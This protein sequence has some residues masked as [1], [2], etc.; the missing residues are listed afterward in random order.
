MPSRLCCQAR[1]WPRC[2]S[3]QS[4]GPGTRSAAIAALQQDTG[5]SFAGSGP[6]NDP[7]QHASPPRRHRDCR[8]AR[9]LL[10]PRARAGHRRRSRSG[11][12]ACRRA[13][14]AGWHAAECCSPG[15]AGATGG[16]GSDSNAGSTRSTGRGGRGAEAGPGTRKS[17]GARRAHGGCGC[18]A[19]I[20]KMERNPG[21]PGTG[22]GTSTAIAGGSRCDPARRSGAAR[23]DTCACRA[24]RQSRLA[25]R[26][27]RPA[28]PGGRGRPC[29]HPQA[30]EKHDGTAPDRRA[31]KVWTNTAGASTSTIAQGSTNHARTCGPVRAYACAA[32]GRSQGHP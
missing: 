7:C 31:R 30:P 29:G 23:N 9:L 4:T 18:T 11:P 32:Q 12:G 21:A 1:W 5:R 3:G 19:R 6:R 20:A 28:R 27:R 16:N 14:S 25:A 26:R 8:A 22:T 24:C 15:R 13:A 2:G 17:A 10:N